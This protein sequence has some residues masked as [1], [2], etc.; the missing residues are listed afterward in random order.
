MRPVFL[1][2]ALGALLLALIYQSEWLSTF[3][4]IGGILAV[5]LGLAILIAAHVSLVA[6]SKFSAVYPKPTT[7]RKTIHRY[8][9]VSTQLFYPTLCIF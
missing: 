5:A 7:E 3:L 2:S 6:R 1:V 4:I 9:M 8:L